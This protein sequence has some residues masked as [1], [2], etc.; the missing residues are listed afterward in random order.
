MAEKQIPMGKHSVRKIL[1]ALTAVLLGG[2]YA[3]AQVISF[4]ISQYEKT[5]NTRLVLHVA[6]SGS[7]NP[8]GYA[9]V[10]LVPAGD[11]TIV[12]FTLTDEQGKAE[13]KKV[14]QG[15]Y[16][17]NVESIGYMP[18]SK[19]YEIK[20]YEKDLGLISLEENPEY[21]DAATI[22]ALADPMTV[23][24]DTLEYNAAAF[25]VGTNDMLEDL[26]KKMP[27][28][29]V[30]ED[31]SVTVGGEKI[32]KITVGGKTFFF[33]DPKMAV[34]NLPAKIV[35]KIKVINKDKDAAAFSG[36]AT[37]EDK[38]KVMD[39]V[40]KE[41]YKQ[42][43]FGNMKA[44]GGGSP[45]S[46]E[47]RLETGQQAFL[48]D[49]SAM[50]S[51]Y[52][53]NDQLV[54]LANGKNVDGNNM[55][56]ISYDGM[57]SG[58]MSG[59]RGINTGAQAGVNYNT[60]KSKT[61]EASLSACYNYGRVDAREKKNRHTW[62]K[63]D[64]KLENGS[65]FEGV[66][67][68]HN[69]LINFEIEN[70]NR[71][72]FRFDLNGG[73]KYT[74][75][76][77]NMHENSFTLGES[78]MPD[79]TESGMDTLNRGRSSQNILSD[80]FNTRG[81]FAAGVK[82]LAKEGRSLSIG[83]N[84]MWRKIASGMDEIS[85]TTVSG[86]ELLKNLS[87]DKDRDYVN[88]DAQMDYV[89]PFGKYWKI[90]VRARLRF[91]SDSND[92]RAFNNILMAED[93]YYSSVS[94]N[95][96]LCIS[97]RFVVQYKKDI[98]NLQFGAMAEQERNET[99]ARAFSQESRSGVDEWLYNWSPYL[100]LRFNAGNQ[101]VN[102][103]YN[104]RSQ[105]PSGLKISPVLDLSNPLY[106]R[107]GNI[108]L[109]PE[110]SNNFSFSWW[111]NSKDNRFNFNIYGYGSLGLRGTVEASWFDSDGIRYAVPVNSDSPSVN[112]AMY[113]DGEVILDRKR[114]FTLDLSLNGR[115]GRSVSYQSISRNSP[116]DRDAFDYTG[117][118]E[119]FWGDAS[120]NRFYGGESGFGRSI[121]GSGSY[122]ST[123]SLRFRNDNFDVAAGASFSNS[124]SHYSLDSKANTNYWYYMAG[125]NAKWENESGWSV[126]SD[127]AYTGYAGYYDNTPQVI[128]NA[129]LSKSIKAVT[130]SIKAVDLLNQTRRISRSAN[131]DYVEE[132]W[133]NAIGRYIVF[134]ISFNFGKMNAKQNNAVR[135]AIWNM[136]L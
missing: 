8:L 13:I 96:D 64:G 34:K 110:Y 16:V 28:M 47:N 120:G 20:G 3:E 132:T 77:E 86:S 15:K 133:R 100:N 1:A 40:L 50:V 7:N 55:V 125:V 23:K 51:G 68:T 94:R 72:K 44:E 124:I 74:R 60:D 80:V 42:G 65:L 36:V 93:D 17:V 48:F 101:R 19:V 127:I 91:V 135:N 54:V 61:V 21:I 33:N 6:E 45:V 26:L 105:T 9:T 114:R 49:A 69:A 63:D 129:S 30:A 112:G 75:S 88:L 90:L 73:F 89:E 97:E 109:K 32:D 5:L 116:L 106:V 27:G 22:T 104:G 67:N 18:F 25:R 35:D 122:G 126:A 95:R 12:H 131:A 38:E 83:G 4:D 43:W 102:I 118:M 121:T 62:L 82:D 52:S 58:G 107:T 103:D 123:L 46:R 53:E 14:V 92:D 71:K 108:Y 39:V 136:V 113:L 119:E 57:E 29:E 130:L 84:V 81:A 41:E 85:L 2:I 111:G 10:Y 70:K 87:H 56:M 37:S 76:S 78:G 115:L 31:G 98:Y 66:S 59:K 134:G 11:T 24:G 99:Y 79:G 128:W 117:F